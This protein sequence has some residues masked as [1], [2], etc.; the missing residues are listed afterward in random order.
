M[1]KGRSVAPVNRNELC[2]QLSATAKSEDRIRRVIQF[3]NQ[4]VPNFLRD[5]HEFEKR[6]RRSRLVVK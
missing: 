3:P 1:S 5:L 2:K 6:S 4:D